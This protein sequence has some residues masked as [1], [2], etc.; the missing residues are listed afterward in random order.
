[1]L[2][3]ERISGMKKGVGGGKSR[4]QTFGSCEPGVQHGE[5]ADLRKGKARDQHSQEKRDSWKRIASGTD[6]SPK[7][8]KLKKGVAKRRKSEGENKNPRSAADRPQKHQKRFQNGIHNPVSCHKSKG[9][10]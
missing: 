9:K 5:R 6:L 2:T 7:P 10:R 4:V 1:M 3:M 8:R